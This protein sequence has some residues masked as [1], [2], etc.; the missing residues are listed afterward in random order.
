MKAVLAMAAA[1][2]LTSMPAAAG[3]L[4]ARTNQWRPTSC[5]E[6]T[7]P[8]R[9]TTDATSLNDSVIRYNAYVDR[10]AAY[11]DCV[12]A[13]AERDMQTIRAQAERAQITAVR[14]A[15]AGRI[16]PAIPR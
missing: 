16:A 13:E 11:N 8:P 12:R 1:A 9:E 2:V 4:D 5:T 7:A 3:Q 14:E 6:P 15:Q 10:V